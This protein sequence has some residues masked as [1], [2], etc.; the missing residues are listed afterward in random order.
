MLAKVTNVDAITLIMA[1]ETRKICHI[2][3]IRCS[4]NV[5]VQGIIHISGQ[6]INKEKPFYPLIKEHFWFTT[7]P[8]Q[9]N[10]TQV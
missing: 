6:L 4:I 3:I 9:S 2:I 1:D 10:L 5:Q 7:V 8:L